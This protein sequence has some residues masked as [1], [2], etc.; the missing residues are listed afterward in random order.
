MVDSSRDSTIWS[1]RNDSWAASN[2]APHET[3][4]RVAPW[5]LKASGTKRG[6]FSFLLFWKPVFWEIKGD[7]ITRKKKTKKKHF[8]RNIKSFLRTISIL[9]TW[10][11]QK[12]D[13]NTWERTISCAYKFQK[14]KR[15]LAPLSVLEKPS[16]AESKLRLL[17]V[18]RVDSKVSKKWRWCLPTQK[19]SIR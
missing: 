15:P 17:K 7:G 16:L 6:P 11:I 18:L 4:R 1:P 13:R 19:K 10:K 3:Q 2:T 5:P 9:R 8:F 12:G 14:E